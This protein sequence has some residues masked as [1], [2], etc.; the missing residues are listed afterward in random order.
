MQHTVVV[1]KKAQEVM[2]PGEGF[3]KALSSGGNVKHQPTTPSFPWQ[4]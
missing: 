4:G 3:K 2:K 1:I